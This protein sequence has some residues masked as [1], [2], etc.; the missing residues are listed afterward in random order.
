MQNHIKILTSGGIDLILTS[1]GIDPS[2]VNMKSMPPDPSEGS[3]G[4]DLILTSGGIDLI[5]NSGGI[6]L[7][8][9]SGGIDPSVVNMRSMPP[10]PSELGVLGRLGA[11]TWSQH[12]PKMIPKGVA[13]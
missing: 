7:I 9:T 4:I 5:L 10:D 11:S 12:D 8:L 2:V 1:G 6:D 3:G 13:S